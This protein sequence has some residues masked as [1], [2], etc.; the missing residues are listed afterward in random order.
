VLSGEDIK[1]YTEIVQDAVSACAI[2]AITCIPMAHRD[3]RTAEIIGQMFTDA[4]KDIVEKTNV[5]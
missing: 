1:T 5:R 4:V 2:V 3:K